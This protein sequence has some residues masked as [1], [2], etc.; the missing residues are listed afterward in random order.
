[1]L[2]K[3]DSRRFSKAKTSRLRLD[4]T[5]VAVLAEVYSVYLTSFLFSA[6]TCVSGSDASD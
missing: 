5:P 4:G 2:A 1:M 6:R 3:V